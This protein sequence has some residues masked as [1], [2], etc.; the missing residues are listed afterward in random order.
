[1]HRYWQITQKTIPSR[2]TWIIS[3]GKNKAFIKNQLVYFLLRLVN[4][5][6]HLCPHQHVQMISPVFMLPF[7]LAGGLLQAGHRG[8]N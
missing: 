8:G 2:R 7:V 4:V 5:L 3:F 1:M 6:D